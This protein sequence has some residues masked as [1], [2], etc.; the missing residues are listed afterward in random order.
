MGGYLRDLVFPKYRLRI[1]EN[2]ALNKRV[3]LDLRRG[4]N[5]E[6]EETA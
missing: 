3:H 2:E 4:S 6:I 5:S 1:F